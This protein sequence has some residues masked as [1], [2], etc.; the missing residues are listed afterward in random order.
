MM[1]VDEITFGDDLHFLSQHDDVIVLKGDDPDARVI[2]SAAYQAKV[3]TSTCGGDDGPSFGWINYK[4]F[5]GERDRHMNAYGGENR[6]WL[7][8]EGGRYSLFF[9]PGEEMVFDNWRTPPAIDT[10]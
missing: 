4:A 10:E 2:A 7:G 5:A 1:Q 8:P 9:K 6:F 3:F